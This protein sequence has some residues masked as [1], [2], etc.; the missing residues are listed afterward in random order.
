MIGALREKG[1]YIGTHIASC[2]GIS[3]RGFSDLTS[4]INELN[5]KSF[6]VLDGAKGD[7]MIREIEKET[8]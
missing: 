2:A 3:D 7:D 8:T 6:A 4:D 5:S 1:I